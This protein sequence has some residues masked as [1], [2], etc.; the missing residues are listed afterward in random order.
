M[1]MRHNLFYE[2]VCTYNIHDRL[3]YMSTVL[4]I[5]TKYVHTLNIYCISSSPCFY[6]ELIFVA[7]NNE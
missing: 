3:V 1:S 7:I 4:L 2:K 5:T 6:I